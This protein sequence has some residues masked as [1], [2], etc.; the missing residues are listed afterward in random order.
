MWPIQS[1]KKKEIKLL[2]P[3]NCYCVPKIITIMG[4][5]FSLSW[6]FLYYSECMF[7]SSWSSHLREIDFIHQKHIQ[8]HEF[9][10][11]TTIA[12]DI[13]KSLYDCGCDHFFVPSVQWLIRLTHSVISILNYYNSERVCLAFIPKKL[14]ETEKIQ[15]KKRDRKSNTIGLFDDEF[16]YFCDMRWLSYPAEL[17]VNFPILWS[18]ISM[19]KWKENERRRQTERLV[20]I[21]WDFNRWHCLK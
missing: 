12:Y 19:L 9:F 18:N 21:E 2:I 6:F 1:V 5:L 17:L 15:R 13:T 20:K 14:N 4:N 8:T 7:V 11:I 3:N 16:K 10:Y